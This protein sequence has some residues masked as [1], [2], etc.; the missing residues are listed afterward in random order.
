MRAAV[1]ALLDGESTPDR[2]AVDEHLGRC[3]ECAAWRDAA[4]ALSRT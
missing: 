3:G 1:S 4:E 2:A